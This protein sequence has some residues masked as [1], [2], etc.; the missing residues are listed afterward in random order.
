[1]VH[2][3]GCDIPTKCY[4]LWLKRLCSFGK[5]ICMLH[6]FFEG[7]MGPPSQK[8]FTFLVPIQIH[9]S[10]FI[11]NSQIH[12]FII[13]MF[14]SGPTHRQVS[15]H[16]ACLHNKVPHPRS[17]ILPQCSSTDGLISPLPVTLFSSQQPPYIS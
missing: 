13:L 16:V 11:L 17:S 10:H 9:L 14:F 2:D 6:H 12:L 4:V 5:N 15:I 7:A 8:L 1:M 3:R